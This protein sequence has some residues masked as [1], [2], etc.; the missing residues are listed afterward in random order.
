MGLGATVVSGT[1]RVQATPAAAHL[2]RGVDGH[3]LQ[4]RA[5]VL[6]VHPPRHLPVVEVV[7]LFR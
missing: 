5:W 2:A 4:V 6:P 3:L 1:G 7:Q